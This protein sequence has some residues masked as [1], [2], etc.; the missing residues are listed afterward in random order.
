MTEPSRPSSE[1]AAD[2]VRSVRSV[3]G[4]AALIIALATL[5]GRGLGLARDAVVSA[6]FGATAATDAFNLAYKL[7][8]LLVVIAAAALTA[9]FVPLFSYRLATGRKEEAWKLSVNI[10]NIISLILVVLT[11]VLIVVAP[12]L[13]AL[14][15]RGFKDRTIVSEKVVPLFRIMMLGFTFQG[16]TGLLIGML[17]SLKRFALAAFA[18]ALGTGVTLV[19]TIALAKSMGITALAIGTAVGW[20]VGLLVLFPGLRGQGIHYRFSIDWRDPTVREV[21]GMVWPILLG[22]AVG[23]VGM[24]A[25]QILG[26]MLE[27]GAVTSLNIADKLFQLPLG[28]FVAGITV[29]IFPLLSEQVAARAPERVKATLDFALRLMGFILVPATV[30]LVLL[31]YPLI[32][33]LFEHGKFTSADTARTAWAF[34]FEVVGLYAYAGRDTVT[35][36]FYA[37]H[38]TRTPIKIGM[39]TVVVSIGLSYLLM[40]SMGVGGLALGTT[41]ALGLNLLVLALLLRR[42][43]GAIGF[44]R[45]G[46]SMLRILAVSAAMGAAIWAID[47]AL[48]SRLNQNTAGYALRLAAGVVVGPAVFYGLSRLVKMSELAETK[49]M[50]RVVFNRPRRDVGAA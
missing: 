6:F 17:N 34:L 31:R 7:P 23:A 4:R 25:A 42:K 48:A 26:T 14:I 13:M 8:Y 22:A 49:D 37:H 11:V 20:T 43:I 16:L 9:T 1:G 18:P 40:Q 27:E 33:L 21:G 29:P 32:G 41:L 19:I 2:P 10:G 38:D 12:W 5:V 35:R 47:F 24:F 46:R 30:G 15:G 50:L 36:V 45:I 44:R 28:L 3:V 39:V